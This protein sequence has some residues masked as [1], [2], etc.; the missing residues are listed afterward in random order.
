LHHPKQTQ[1]PGV[2]FTLIDPLTKATAVNVAFQQDPTYGPIVQDEQRFGDSAGID[3]HPIS[4]RIWSANLCVWAPA[5]TVDAA[6]VKSNAGAR[7]TIF[8]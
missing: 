1:P 7:I 6:T 8:S 3:M 4:G 2:G 5:Y